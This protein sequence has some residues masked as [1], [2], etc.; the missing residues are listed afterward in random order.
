M[1]EQVE[2]NIEEKAVQAQPQNNQPVESKDE[3]NPQQIDWRK[4]KEARRVERQ[5]KEEAERRAAQKTAEAEALKAAMEALLNKPVNN[6]V[7]NYDQDESEE[8]RIQK[9]IDAALAK[10][11][12]KAEEERIRREHAEFPQRLAQTYN[13]FDQVCSEENLDYLEYHYPE[14]AA[15]FKN[16]PD[17]F[18]KWS[19]VYKAVKRFLPNATNNKDQKKAEKNFSKPQAMSVPGVTTT[20]DHA[21]VMLDDQRRKDN[22]NRMQRVMRGGK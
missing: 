8:D 9:K 21:P 6:S 10:E 7:N 4:F 14:V 16:A 12:Q 17:S 2:T 13:D 15:A 18:D 1:E 22:W 19:N 20:S 5:Q 3:E 11:R